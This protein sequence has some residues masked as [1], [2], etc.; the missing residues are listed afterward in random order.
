VSRSRRAVR[1][2][3][4]GLVVGAL[5]CSPPPGAAPWPCWEPPSSPIFKADL[6]S[7][8]N[9]FNGFLTQ[10]TECCRGVVHRSL[11]LVAGRRVVIWGQS[12]SFDSIQQARLQKK[13]HRA[14]VDPLLPSV[15]FNRG[16]NVVA[17]GGGT[18]PGHPASVAS[19]AQ[20]ATS[21]RL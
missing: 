1:W 13:C 2:L 16:P 12:R 9:H 5:E 4:P 7:R 8:W 15:A 18:G 19:S 10:L 6:L 11:V 14:A 21:Q 17:I 20:Q 3:Q